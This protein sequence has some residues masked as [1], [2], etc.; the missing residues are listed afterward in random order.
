MMMLKWLA[1]AIL[2]FYAGLSFAQDKGFEKPDYKKIERVTK[3]KSSEFYYPKLFSRYIANDTTLSVEQ[4][5]MLYYGFFFQEGYSSFGS[6]S[7]FNDSMKALFNKESLTNA[8]RRDIIR[9]TKEDL[10]TS[11]FSLR[12]LYRLYRFYNI[13]GDDADG[14][15]C[16][17]KLETLAK[18]IS[19]TGDARTD[20]TGIHVLS[21]EDEYAIVSMLGY[22]F[23]GTQTLTGNQCDYLTLKK[24]D[25]NIDGLYFDVKQIFAGYS[26]ALGEDKKTQKEKKSK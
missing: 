17:Y 14:N 4:Y 25:D 5:K 11:P 9:Y 12:D 18:A 1:V 6:T 3:D 21:V 23:G 22:E 2:S 24:N 20:T 13:L 8:D 15:L 10:K 16:R 26:K 19:S 7:A